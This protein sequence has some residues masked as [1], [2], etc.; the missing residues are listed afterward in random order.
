MTGGR[1]WPEPL[2]ARL[3]AYEGELGVEALDEATVSALAGHRA[4]VDAIRADPDATG[5]AYWIVG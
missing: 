2:D 3:R 4:A 5:C 1:A